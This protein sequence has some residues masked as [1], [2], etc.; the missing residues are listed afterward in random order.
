VNRKGREALKLMWM[1]IAE[2]EKFKIYISVEDI[3]KP[4]PHPDTH[5]P[6]LNSDPNIYD[7]SDNLT[8]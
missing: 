2:Q 8:I 4:K 7:N 1:A 6:T 5:T 3:I